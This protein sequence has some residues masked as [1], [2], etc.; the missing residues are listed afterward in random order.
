MVNN[1]V[2]CQFQRIPQ[3]YEKIL[4]TNPVSLK[5]FGNG[6]NED[7]IRK[8][9]VSTK[10]VLRRAGGDED[11][12]RNPTQEAIDWANQTFD[13]LTPYLK[14]RPDS[15]VETINEPNPTVVNNGVLDF[16]ASVQ[17]ALKLNEYQVSCANR[18]HQLGVKS[19]GAYQFSV[20]QPP[21]EAFNGAQSLWP[22]L[23]DGIIASEYLLCHEYSAP[24]MQSR[25]EAYCLRIFH[26]LDE[27]R[28]MNAN[29]KV[30]LTEV[31]IDF[32]VVAGQLG[33]YKTNG[34]PIQDYTA[35][36]RWY[37]DSLVR[38]PSIEFAHVFLCG[39]SDDHWATFDVADE[40]TD[41]A[42]FIEFLK[43]KPNVQPPVP[44]EEHETRQ[45]AAWNSTGVAFNPDAALFKKAQELKLGYPVANEYQYMASDGKQ[46][47]GQGFALA[48]I[49]CITN[50]WANVKAYDWLTGQSYVTPPVTPPSGGIPPFSC[51][52]SVGDN[53]AVC[54]ETS[55]ITGKPFYRLTGVTVRQGVSAFCAVTVIGKN[56]IPVIGAKVINQFRG[57][58]NG[59]LILTDGSGTARF[60]FG[61]SSASS[62]AGQG[63][64]TFSVSLD[65]I[66]DTDNHVLVPGTILSDKVTSVSDWQ[67]QHTEWSIQLV[68]VA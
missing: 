54:V 35:Q 18:L 57:S 59:E 21:C 9:P 25:G 37:A 56:G 1:P 40:D 5:F 43:Y 24:T 58:A 33:G 53:G 38:E 17:L 66:K 64:F 34:T 41:R 61:A 10:I 49:E 31:G 19:V 32:G 6:L 20:G 65:A 30:G 42:V 45:E 27:L 68:Q 60:Q 28:S 52:Q 46:Y 51:P 26:V 63:P 14:I 48:F 4:A 13:V 11:F 8:V 67:G 2:T 12:T 22:F 55:P 16:N 47:T 3:D 29:P 7:A 44:P 23:L 36:L 39:R 15:I 62:V 50:D